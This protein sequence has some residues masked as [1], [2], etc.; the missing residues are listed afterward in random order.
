MRVLTRLSTLSVV[1]VAAG[2]TLA[3]VAGA[4]VTDCTYTKSKKL[5]TLTIDNSDTTGWLQI[6]RQVGT[7]RIGYWAEGN[8]DWSGCEGARTTDTDKVKVV[9]SSLSEEIYIDLTNGAFVPGASN[10]SAGID[11]IE[12]DLD[13]GPGTDEVT[14]IGG[15]GRDHLSFNKPT[16]ASLNSDVDADVTLD[17]VDVFALEGGEGND[18]LDGAGVPRVTIYGEEGDDRLIGGAG[19]DSLYGDDWDDNTADGNDTILGG[20]GDD[21]L[22]GFKGADRLVGGDEDDGLRGGIGND[23]LVGG[24][25]DDN[26][27][28]ES[29]K[30]GADDLDGGS[31]W[32]S[33]EY[34]NRSSNLRVSL[35]GKDN[36][37]GKNEGDDVAPNVEEVEGGNGNDQLVGNHQPNT[38]RGGNG[39]DVLKGLAGDDGLDDGL[40]N[41]QVVGG[42]G[43]E[44]LDNDPGAD[45]FNLG[46][47]DDTIYNDD[48]D[49]AGDVLIGGA[50][51]DAVTYEPRSAAVFIDVTDGSNDG[52]AGEGD[53]VSADF[54]SIT[55]GSSD[56]EIW[57]SG[58]A[59][60]IYGG[61]GSDILNGR[62]GGDDLF[63]SSGNDQLTGGEGYDYHYGSSGADTHYAQD[64]G[65]DLVDCGAVGD[66]D[67][68]ATFDAY[69]DFDNC[70][71]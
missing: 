61:N 56:D 29:S 43:D 20:A 23:D 16:S 49:G 62:G 63:G 48:T 7:N 32:D 10:E 1:I 44:W 55:G 17:G 40:G 3:P 14:I 2:V 31:G 70:P 57:G 41:D 47:G 13:L 52:T 5:V 27:F 51:R 35:D 60:S 64:N 50:G 36:D 28:A 15:R 45:S 18:V 26:F 69:D 34:C 42:P 19:R 11:E 67:V 21:T 8:P 22:Y 66:G 54:E 4:E 30:D 46:D 38:L 65:E 6:E 33:A 25:G 9:G 53:K 37:G 39:N 24:P 71:L 68:I 58:R 59:E 12:F